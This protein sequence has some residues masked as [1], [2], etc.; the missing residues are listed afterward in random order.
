MPNQ[1]LDFSAK[2]QDDYILYKFNVKNILDSETTFEQ[3]KIVTQHY[4]TGRS[5]S[6]GID[7]SL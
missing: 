5:F 1:K 3:N 7:L 6:F 2:Y 4:K